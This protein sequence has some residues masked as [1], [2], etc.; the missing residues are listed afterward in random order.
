M[1]INLAFLLTSSQRIRE[2]RHINSSHMFLALLTASHTHT[3]THHE[4]QSCLY[5]GRREYSPLQHDILVIE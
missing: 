1:L 5:C 3:H 4:V 2:K